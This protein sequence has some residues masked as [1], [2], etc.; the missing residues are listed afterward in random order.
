MSLFDKNSSAAK[1]APDSQEWIKLVTSI[2]V[3]Y[4]EKKNST[5]KHGFEHFYSKYM[6]AENE[7]SEETDENDKSD[8]TEMV[9]LE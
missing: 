2:P 1:F 5:A 9:L 7:T 3:C 6:K 4:M 8:K